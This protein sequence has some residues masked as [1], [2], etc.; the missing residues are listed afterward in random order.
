MSTAPLI[1]PPSREL[2]EDLRALSARPLFTLIGI[3]FARP[4][5]ALPTMRDPLPLPT[6]TTRHPA[7][8]ARWKRKTAQAHK[9]YWRLFRRTG[10][11]DTRAGK[12][13]SRVLN[14][15]R[16]CDR[17]CGSRRFL[18]HVV[19]TG[20]ILCVE[21]AGLWNYCAACNELATNLDETF[22]CEFCQP[23]ADVNRWR[24]AQ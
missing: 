6:T 23:C 12:K 9:N 17:R 2:R 1:I 7:Q 4:A 3:D 19:G 15:V 18:A 13:W 24:V 8:I 10:R 22:S 11:F 14:S 20:A 5:L 16:L 21:C